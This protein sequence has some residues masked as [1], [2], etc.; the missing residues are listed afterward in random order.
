MVQRAENSFLTVPAFVSI[1]LLIDDGKQDCPQL[2]TSD[3]AFKTLD[4]KS[5]ESKDS[6]EKTEEA[7]KNSSITG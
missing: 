3:T 6:R 5:T 1:W 2:Y 7:P 4:L